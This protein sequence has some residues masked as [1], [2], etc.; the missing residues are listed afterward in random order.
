MNQEQA[1]RERNTPMPP[2]IGFRAWRDQ[3]LLALAEGDDEAGGALVNLGQLASTRL[4]A[5][6]PGW[7][8]KA[9]KLFEREGWIELSLTIGGGVDEGLHATLTGEG[10][11]A[12]ER[13]RAH[14]AEPIANSGGARATDPV[15]AEVIPAADRFVALDHNSAEYKNAVESVD[16]LTNAIR[17][18]NIPLFVDQSQR[19]AVMRE[20]EGIRNL[21]NGTSV[22]L[23]AIAQHIR[24]GGFL[25]WLVVAAGAGVVGNYAYAA[26]EALRRLVGL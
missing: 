1:D 15:E 26:I 3:L 8:R 22:R 5:F 14:L 18:T 19:L 6:A 10:L 9:A 21:L 13:L 12:A 24:A 17:T 7:V 25:P 16:R 4:P 2:P 23:A 20:A 11:E